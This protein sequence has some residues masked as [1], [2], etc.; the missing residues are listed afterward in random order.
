VFSAIRFSSGVSA[1]AVAFAFGMC[2]KVNEERK[3]Y[4]SIS[5]ISV[6]DSGIPRHDISLG[7]CFPMF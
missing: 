4:K 2:L 6:D 3:D 7:Y 1:I 5:N